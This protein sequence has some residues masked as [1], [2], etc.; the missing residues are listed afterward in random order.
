MSI[1]DIDY[2]VVEKKSQFADVMAKKVGS[3]VDLMYENDRFQLMRA[4]M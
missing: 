2:F 3:L 4:R 1:P